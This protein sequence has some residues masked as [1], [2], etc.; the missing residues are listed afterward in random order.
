M[1]IWLRGKIRMWGMS[2]RR[3]FRLE[4]RTIY[5]DWLVGW[6][7]GTH[8]EDWLVAWQEPLMRIE[9]LIGCNFF[10]EEWLLIGWQEPL[11]RIT[12]SPACR[13]WGLGPTTT[14]SFTSG[15]SSSSPCRWSSDRTNRGWLMISSNRSNM[16]FF[17]TP[18][19]GSVSLEATGAKVVSIDKFSFN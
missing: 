4:T 8:G 9:C 3:H 1:D 14:T 13:P 6:L 18:V 10:Y 11:E 16:W 19:Q 2:P 17:M 5:Q 7:P 12:A 15:S